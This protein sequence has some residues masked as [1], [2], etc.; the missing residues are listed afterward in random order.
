MN[1]KILALLAS[2]CL[3]AP[4]L[5][6]ATTSAS[7]AAPVELNGYFVDS[8]GRDNGDW[9]FQTCAKKGALKEIE[10]GSDNGRVRLKR[11]KIS[12]TNSQRIYTWRNSKALYQVTWQTKDPDHVRF[13]VFKPSGKMIV[14]TQMNRDFDGCENQNN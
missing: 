4:T 11:V 5:S 6:L 2:F 13:R 9:N 1:T 10:I 7:N 14:N 8:R 3:T 12:G